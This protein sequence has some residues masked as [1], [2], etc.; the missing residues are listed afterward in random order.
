MTISDRKKGAPNVMLFVPQL[1]DEGASGSLD[2]ASADNSYIDGTE[3]GMRHR[4][5]RNPYE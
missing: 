5:R 2:V 4:S 1:H 3:T